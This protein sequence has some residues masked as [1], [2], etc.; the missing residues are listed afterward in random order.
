[1]A[2]LGSVGMAIVYGLKVNLSVAMVIMVNNTAL[3]IDSLKNQAT[4]CND[5][6]ANLRESLQHQSAPLISNQTILEPIANKTALCTE[7]TT[8]LNGLLHS[9]PNVAAKREVS[10]RNTN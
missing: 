1:M 8:T 9:E 4:L 2:I 5:S 7:I 10:T 3:K 6:L